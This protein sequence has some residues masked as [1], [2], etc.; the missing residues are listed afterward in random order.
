MK[1][2]RAINASHLTK[3]NDAMNLQ[4]DFLKHA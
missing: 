3:M 1:D 2:K 4:K